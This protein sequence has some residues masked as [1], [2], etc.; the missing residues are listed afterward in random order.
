MY[1]IDDSSIT[2]FPSYFDYVI[3]VPG[4][5]DLIGNNVPYTNTWDKNITLTTDGTVNGTFTFYWFDP[6]INAVIGT[7][8]YVENF[9]VVL[10]CL[11]PNGITSSSNHNSL[12]TVSDGSCLFDNPFISPILNIGTIP[13]Q[14]NI[15]L[16][17]G[18]VFNEHQFYVDDSTS[19]FAYDNTG[20]ADATHEPYI[21][22][23][24]YAKD[25][26]TVDATIAGDWSGNAGWTTVPTKANI[27]LIKSSST[28]DNSQLL[29]SVNE[30]F[31]PAHMP[32]FES[33]V[34]SGETTPFV[35]NYGTPFDPSTNPT[36]PALISSHVSLTEAQWALDGVDT[37]FGFRLK[38]TDAN[39]RV[40]RS[41]EVTVIIN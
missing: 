8:S 23:M 12:V 15:D 1:S 37:Y 33:P 25:S 17:G 19:A 3:T 13:L 14:Q 5:P 16:G 11:D 34:T 21:Y 24:E 10:G 20:V 40:Q 36:S 9:D 26:G 27:P 41:N 2:D 7:R 38:V 32:G 35:G 39:G 29:I 6:T 18:I 31:Q 22:E 4:Q 28:F 30:L